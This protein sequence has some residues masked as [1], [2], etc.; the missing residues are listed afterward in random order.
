MAKIINNIFISEEL[1]AEQNN[2]VN[3][4]ARET[5]TNCQAA[6][7]AGDRKKVLRYRDRFVCKTS[8]LIDNEDRIIAI[9]AAVAYLATF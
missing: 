4:L 3:A 9:K 7:I 6:E 8:G 1:T 5:V 2:A